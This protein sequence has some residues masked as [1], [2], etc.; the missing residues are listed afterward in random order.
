MTSH[1]TH[2]RVVAAAAL[3]AVG[4]S[5]VAAAATKEEHTHG[6]AW[7]TITH[8]VGQDHYIA[9]DFKDSKLGS[10]AIVYVS[11]VSATS[12]P[13]T[14]H[15]DAIKITLYT[16]RGSLQGTGAGDDVITP[17]SAT[18]TNGTFS[19]TKGTGAYKGHTFKGTFGGPATQGVYKFTYK[20]VYR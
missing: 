17:S 2:L 18:V 8:A 16:A 10:G 15:V 7:V 14:F 20:A 5:G 19:L 4:V 3:L 11:H 6:V 1:L 12:T 13:G 9:G